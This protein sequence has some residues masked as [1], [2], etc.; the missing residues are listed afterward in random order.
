MPEIK[1]SKMETDQRLALINALQGELIRESDEFKA[2][3]ETYGA[4][5]WIGK[6]AKNFRQIFEEIW[7]EIEND[8]H[9]ADAIAMMENGDNHVIKE[10]LLKMIKPRLEK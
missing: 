9:Y 10:Q 3:G 6:Y 4:L 1:E 2:K 8:Q 7:A 5:E